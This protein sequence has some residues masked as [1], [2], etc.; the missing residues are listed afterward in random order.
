V[1]NAQ[2]KAGATEP[3]LHGGLDVERAKEGTFGPVR[4]CLGGSHTGFRKYASYQ[5]QR[6]ARTSEHQEKCSKKVLNLGH[7]R[8]TV[9]NATHKKERFSSWVGN[10]SVNFFDIL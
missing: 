10:L 4:R 6:T 2:L 8:I 7:M 5:F 3:K 1:V 9:S